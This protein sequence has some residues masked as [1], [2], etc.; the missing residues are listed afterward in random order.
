MK[1]TLLVLLI[2]VASM[3]MVFAQGAAEPIEKFPSKPVTALLGWAAGGG[4]DI[5]FRALAEVFPKYANGQPLIIQNQ[6][7]AAGVPAIT[8]FMKAP[9][10]GYHTLHW[11]VAHVIKTHMTQTPFTGTEFDPVLQVVASFN[12]LVVNADAK[13]NTLAEFIAD[14]KARPEGISMGNAGAGGG[15]HMAALLF[16][17][18]SG[19]QYIHVPFSGGGPAIT[20]LMSGQCDAVMANAPEGIANVQAGQLKILAVFS[21]DRLDS[22]PAKTG[23][24]QGV[25]LVLEQ[26]R[27]VVVPKGTP[28]AL[29]AKLEEIFRQCVEDPVYIKKME[30]LG[31]IPVYRNGPD[32][33]KL[34]AD[35]DARYEK[36]V[37]EGKFGDKY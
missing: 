5:V 2:L 33:G 34:V 15:N 3:S 6:G 7:A 35:D 37:R 36:I 22:I 28:P 12:Y 25:D 10:D 17:E 4:G 8:E 29:I 31:S 24:E 14:A 11:N 21:N 1:K 27:G 20:G 18:A 16:E 32:F 23:L 26:W 9:A 30:E 19:T 13:W